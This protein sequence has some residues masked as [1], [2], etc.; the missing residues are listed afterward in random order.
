MGDE[1]KR[2][3]A[4]EPR[5]ERALYRVLSDCREPIAFSDLA[6]RMNS[7]PELKIHV[8]DPA[9]LV[10]WLVDAGAIEVLPRE[11]EAEDDD[12]AIAEESVDE[13]EPSDSAEIKELSR[14]AREEGC[15]EVLAI[16][17]AGLEAWREHEDSDGIARLFASSGA[18]E[19]TFRRVLELCRESRG[20]KELESALVAEGLLDTSERQASYFLDK[21]EQAE[22]I[23]WDGGWKTTRKGL[24]HIGTR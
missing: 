22:G 10:S 24:S 20:T 14:G 17:D 21:L 6:E 2:R 12:G 11:G 3:I 9:T 8:L 19:E 23:V 16:T 1:I 13:I 18:L 4:A 7:Y 5:Y 15:D